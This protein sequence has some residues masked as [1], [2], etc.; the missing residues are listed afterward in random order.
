MKNLFTLLFSTICVYAIA[1]T[2]GQPIGGI[3][4]KGGKNP[5]WNTL[6]SVSGGVSNPGSSIRTKTNL[7]NGYALS[8][9]IYTP[10]CQRRKWEFSWP[11]GTLL[12]YWC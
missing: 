9:N 1:Q 11:Y 2:P 3:V 10:V 6:L 7:V 5:G 8:G 4:V 12:Y